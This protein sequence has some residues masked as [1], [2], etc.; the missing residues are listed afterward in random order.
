MPVYKV[1]LISIVSKPPVRPIVL[2][3]KECFL[4]RNFAADGSAVRTL[5]YLLRLYLNDLYAVLDWGLVEVCI[6]NFI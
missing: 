1:L 6:N 4:I 2:Y 3:S 5:L